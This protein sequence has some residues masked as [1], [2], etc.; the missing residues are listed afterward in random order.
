[1]VVPPYWW[2]TVEGLF[3]SDPKIGLV[4]AVLSGDGFRCPGLDV[5]DY[6]QLHRSLTLTDEKHRYLPS[7][8]DWNNPDAYLPRVFPDRAFFSKEPSGP[9]F[10]QFTI[11]RSEMLRQIPYVDDY[12]WRLQCFDAGW[13]LAI[14]PGVVVA[15]MKGDIGYHATVGQVRM[16]QA[17]ARHE[18]GTQFTL[19]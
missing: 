2:G 10:D 9:T 1:M 18:D 4:A 16:L 19:P 7:D 13:K 3:N 14:A 12:K 6:Q 15:H 8:T 5:E 17:T 11:F